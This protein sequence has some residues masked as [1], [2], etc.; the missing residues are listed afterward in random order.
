M[1]P[2]MENEI[3]NE[4]PDMEKVVR[5]NELQSEQSVMGKLSP[6]K[7]NELRETLKSL[8]AQMPEE[9]PKEKYNHL[10][11]LLNSMNPDNSAESEKAA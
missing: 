9:D 1:N 2:E 6:E 4:Q 5:I 3:D 11:E 8:L 7:S 10:K